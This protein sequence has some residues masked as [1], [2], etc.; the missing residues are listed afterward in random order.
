MELNELRELISTNALSIERLCNE[1]SN[2]IANKKSEIKLI[3]ST[4]KSISDDPIFKL[5]V[6]QTKDCV[7]KLNNLENKI[8]RIE[9]RIQ[10]GKPQGVIDLTQSEPD[11]GISSKQTDSDRKSYKTVHINKHDDTTFRSNYTTRFSRIIMS[12][13][14]DSTSVHKVLKR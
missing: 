10:S 12:A 9:K 14:T 5:H 1:K 6:P 2:G 7:T 8:N 11:A 4:V 13:Q 3:Q